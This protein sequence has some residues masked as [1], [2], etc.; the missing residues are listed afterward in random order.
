[1]SKE[2]CLRGHEVVVYTSDAKDI[3]SRLTVEP[4]RIL[5]G[6]KVHYMRN[7]SMI[8]IKKLKLFITPELI[9][10]VKNKIKDS[11]VIRLHEYRTFQNIVV[12]HYAKKYDIPYVLQ[13]HGSLPRI[14][15]KQRL[16]LIY[17][18]LFGY[19]LL[20]DASQAI[21]LNHIEAEQY[22]AMGVTE[23]K[24]KVVPN[25]IDSSEYEG[26]PLKGSFK[27]KFHINEDEKIILYLGRIHQIKGLDILVKA[28][29][30]VIEEFEGIRLVIVGP[31]DGYLSEIKILIRALKMED[32]VKLPGPLYGREKLEAYVD[33][34]IYILPS[35]YEAFG[36]SVLEAYSCG[37]PVIAS[38]VEGLSYLVIDSV[39]GLLF[40]PGNF[41]QLTSSIL[42]LLNNKDEA[43]EMGLRGMKFV[44][45]NFSIEKVVD[46]VE[47]TYHKLTD[48]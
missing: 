29:K 37:I 6:I 30:N 36:I 21:A 41:K 27:K 39:T 18:I 26:L 13:A 19:K 23:E 9:F 38:R 5:D 28:F 46:M 48:L 17:D 24:I 12:Y 31:D 34:E 10:K 25:G 4:A 7:L 2:L 20:R 1:M 11:D 35:R 15:S 3:D 40:D 22:L 45:E 44:K 14:V 42:Y 43:S 32:D 33:A 16:K 47:Q 8:P